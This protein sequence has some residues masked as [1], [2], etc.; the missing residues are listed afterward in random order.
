MPD[1]DPP[2]TC[3]MCGGQMTAA[4]AEKAAENSKEVIDAAI[5]HVKEAYR[6]GH[7]VGFAAGAAYVL[8]NY[9]PAAEVLAES[10]NAAQLQTALAQIGDA[11]EVKV[12]GGE[13]DG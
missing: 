2:L 11:R 1:N 12:V 8:K 4:Q 6:D 13:R 9:L 5:N 10:G 7:Q 3:R